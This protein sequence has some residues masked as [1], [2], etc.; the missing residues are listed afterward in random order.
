MEIKNIL[1]ILL[2]GSALSA[3]GGSG[4]DDGS[5]SEGETPVGGDPGN[6]G[7]EVTQEQISD[8]YLADP[9]VW[10]IAAETNFS[11]DIPLDGTTISLSTALDLIL[12]LALEEINGNMISV[13]ACDG[14]GEDVI[15]LN[16]PTLFSP[17]EDFDV[18]TCATLETSFFEISDTSFRQVLECDGETL[19]DFTFTKVSNTPVFDFGSLSFTSASVDSLNATNGVCGSITEATIITEVTPPSDSFE[20]GES[21]ITTFNVGAPYSDDRITFSFLLNTAE[22]IAGTYSISSIAEL[23]DEVEVEI[24][25]L[26]DDD[27][28]GDSGTLTI[29]SVGDQSFS[30]TFNL[31]TDIG[32]HTLTGSFDIDL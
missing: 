6:T 32:G 1:V 22:L 25:G 18:N 26:V 17:D 30:G 13:L 9:G 29:S 14:F 15:D 24:I 27:V 11:F 19:S 28:Y 31:V 20:E 2:L 4:D 5:G 7:T 23:S 12:V 10:K 21:Q 16:D 3:C 8:L